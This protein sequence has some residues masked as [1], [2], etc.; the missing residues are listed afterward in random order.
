MQQVL[1]GA[2]ATIS[3]TFDSAPGATTVTVK[4]QDGT[5]VATY[6]KL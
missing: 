3:A 5:V 4:R 2:A 1:R 6:T